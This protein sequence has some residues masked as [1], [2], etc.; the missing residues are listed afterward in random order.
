M[1][2]TV[3]INHL[4]AQQR[5]EIEESA[6]NTPKNQL[7]YFIEEAQ[8]AF[9]NRSTMRQDSEEFLS[10]FN[11]GRNNKES[12][13]TASQRLSDFSKTIRTKQ[14]YLIGKINMEDITP[15][16]HRIE[17][18]YNINLT[19]TPLRTWY[20]KGETLVSPD[21]IQNKKPFIINAE[22]RKDYSK[23]TF[24]KSVPASDKPKSLL[25]R[26][27]NS[28]FPATQSQPDF[29]SEDTTQSEDKEK[30]ESENQEVDDLL[31]LDP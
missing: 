31:L 21:W 26:I 10:V 1:V 3:V 25:K 24:Y 20:F 4:D 16:I 29:N 8:D 15:Q 27:L 17:K 23:P 13:F 19:E 12:F 30:E 2:P 22:I 9:N 14:T 7:C 18:L 5:Q 28:I 11:E 6:T